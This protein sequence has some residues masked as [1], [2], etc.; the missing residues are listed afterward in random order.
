MITLFLIA[1]G[2]VLYNLALKPVFKKIF[3]QNNRVF[4]L[5]RLVIYRIL[6]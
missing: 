1:I 4:F 2:I 6:C 3:L 5:K